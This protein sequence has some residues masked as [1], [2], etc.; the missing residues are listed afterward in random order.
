MA[1]QLIDMKRL[2]ADST[3]HI[4]AVLHPEG[5]PSVDREENTD[6]DQEDDY[7]NIH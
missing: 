1:A 6:M 5:G 2:H 4:Y 3:Q 7:I